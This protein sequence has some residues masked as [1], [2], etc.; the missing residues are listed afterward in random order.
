LLLGYAPDNPATSDLAYTILRSQEA[1]LKVA[2][3]HNLTQNDEVRV[4]DIEWRSDVINLRL[5]RNRVAQSISINQETGVT[6]F[7]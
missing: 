1:V 6:L 4:Y 2:T 5:V 3:V 7:V